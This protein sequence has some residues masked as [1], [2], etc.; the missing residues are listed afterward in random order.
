MN[1]LKVGLLALSTIIAV[2][3][4][5][6]KVTSNQ[7]G[8]G[9]YVT[10][11]TIVNDASGIFPKTPI[12]VAGIN[13]GRI[14]DIQLQGNKALI[15]FEVLEKVK[16][17]E[18]SKLTIKT[19]GFLGDKYLE[20]YISQEANRLAE[21][22]LIESQM[23]GGI[24]DLAKNAGE[25][26][27]D[28]KT[29]VKKFKEAVAP[30]G[31][32]PPLAKMIQDFKVMAENTKVATESMKNIMSGNE[33]KLNNLISNLESAAVTLNS[34][35][36]QNNKD[37]LMADLK[38]ITGDLKAIVENIRN[39]KGTVGRLLAEDDI[40][41]EVKQTISGVNKLVNR[42][43]SLRT[44]LLVYTGYNTDFGSETSAGLRIYPSPERFYHLGITTSEFGSE[45][46]T[47]TR[48]S[49]NGGTETLET[50]KIRKKD[51][52]RFDV[53]LGRKINNWT[54]RGGLIESAGGIGVD[55]EFEKW[56][57]LL[58]VEAFDYREDIGLNLRVSSEYHL[59]NVFYGKIA[60]EDL[61]HDPSLTLSAGLK[62]NDEDLKGLIG[63]F[64]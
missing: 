7:S 45:D 22:S 48:K 64:F 29:I 24:A 57:A 18:G 10:Y 26:L 2:I 20:I 1:E 13:A 59:W 30:E 44:E 3:Y 56:G 46:E 60:G 4:M 32:E 34:H 9:E 63:F 12:K 43:D 15:I 8:F 17:T 21:N 61:I 41:D 33:E 52:Y 27:D 16:I 5:S 31:Q 23:G 28:V 58:S 25:V 53:M 55:Y 50:T 54:F 40:V 62:F 14:K 11:R 47:E 38:S 37:A 6:F 39:G 42:V 36:D 19:V 49:I 35:M 51:T